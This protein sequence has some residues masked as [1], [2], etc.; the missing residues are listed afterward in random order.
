[1]MQLF[2]RPDAAA[3]EPPPRGLPAGMDRDGPCG[4]VMDP[5]LD[6]LLAAAEAAG[7][8]RGEVLSAALTWIAHRMVDWAQETDAPELWSSVAD[9]PVYLGE[10][11]QMERH[12]LGRWSGGQAR[13]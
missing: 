9:M 2:R 8:E 13:P 11:L 1:M 7:W 3:F 4:E 5:R 12:R 6:A 10:L